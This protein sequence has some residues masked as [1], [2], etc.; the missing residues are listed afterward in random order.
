MPDTNAGER[1]TRDDRAAAVRRQ[2]AAYVRSQRR[3][4]NAKTLAIVGLSAGLA[5]S[6]YSINRLAAK[7]EG[8]EVVYATIQA[9]GDVVS[10]VHYDELPPSAKQGEAVQNAL[11]QYVMARDCYNA[12]GF[13]RQSYIAQAMSEARVGDQVH[14]QFDPA[15]PQAPQHLFGEHG[16]TVQCELMDPPTPMGGNGD[17]YFFRFRRWLDNG[18]VSPAEIAAS[19]FY[20]VSVR[21][22]TGVY[23]DDKRRG[24]VDR[25]TFNAP[26]VQVLDYPGAQPDNARPAI[27]VSQRTSG[28]VK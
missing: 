17:I 18:R 22:R 2:H 16:V 24:W 15:N 27:R 20:S 23:P 3:T 8:K 21:F 7:A 1:N 10:S 13:A 28:D 25:S 11:W 26:G 19:P 6:V 14:R 4:G 9:T 12:P 5:W